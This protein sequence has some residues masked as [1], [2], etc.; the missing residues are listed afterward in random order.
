MDA[1]TGA[2]LPPGEQGE[3][4]VR[5]PQV[6]RGYWQRPDET[7]KVMRGDW[8]RTGDIGLMSDDGYFSIVDRAKDVIIASGLKVFPR[9]VEEALFQHPAVQEAAVIGVPDPYRGETVR[10]YIVLKPGQRATAE[11]LTAFCRE[12]LAVYKIPKQFVFRDELPKSLI[13]KVVRRVLREEA[14]AEAQPQTTES[15]P[16]STTPAQ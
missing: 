9:D 14:A 4:V 10:A 12:R 13:G 8:L 3:I 7:A 2:F 1:A 6:M 5:G 11:E 15:T 16:E